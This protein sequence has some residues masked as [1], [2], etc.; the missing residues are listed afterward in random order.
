MWNT[1]EQCLTGTH[2]H[3]MEEKTAHLHT[4]G[5]IQHNQD[6]TTQPQKNTQHIKEQETHTSEHVDALTNISGGY[7]LYSLSSISP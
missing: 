7:C 6:S 1:H 2:T 5:K 3:V 4:T